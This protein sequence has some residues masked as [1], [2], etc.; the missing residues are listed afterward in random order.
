MEIVNVNCASYSRKILWTWLRAYFWSELVSPIV[1]L[2]FN[3]SRH[4]SFFPSGTM[5]ITM[6]SSTRLGSG[7][8]GCELE[9]AEW[10]IDFNPCPLYPLFSLSSSCTH[11]ALCPESQSIYVRINN[12]CFIIFAL[13]SFLLY[14]I[15][16]H[17]SHNCEKLSF[18]LKRLAIFHSLRRS[19]F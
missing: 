9:L 4:E 12:L 14:D 11:V 5:D 3:D 10:F 1:K 13:K 19:Q 17:G 8:L 15:L 2:D 7:E 16:R 18:F 6:L